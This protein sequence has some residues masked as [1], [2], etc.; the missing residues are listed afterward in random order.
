MEMTSSYNE[1]LYKKR[2]EMK[3]SKKKF[4][5]FLGLPKIYYSYCE[6]G[7]FKP[8][9]KYVE[10]ISSALGIDFSLYLEGA[11]S[12]PTP[13]PDKLGWFER[14]YKKI[15]AKL[16]VRIAF[17]VLLIGSLFMTIFGF[18]RYNYTMDH[19]DEFFN[20]RYLSFAYAMREKGGSTFSLLHEMTRPEI[21]TLEDGKFYSISTS[22]QNYALRSLSAYANYQYDT[23]SLYYIVPNDAKDSLLHV[24]VQ[25]I[26]TDTL[27]KSYGDFYRE[28]KDSS[29][30]LTEGP[31]D[32]T[33]ETIVD[34]KEANS[35]TTIFNSHINDLN[36][37]FTS[38]IKTQLGLDYDFYNEL[39]VDHAQAATD[40]L[41]AEIGSLAIG[42]GGLVLTGGFLFF[43]LFAL[44]FA[45]PKIKRPR[46]KKT[47]PA[48]EN[49]PTNDKIGDD[50]PISR[51]YKS[52]KTDIRFFP[53]I[54]E[55]VFEIVGIFLVLLGSIRIL[56]YTLMLFTTMSYDPAEFNSMNLSLFMY[57]TVGMFLLY[58]IDF[59]VYL[60]DKRSLR[61]S[62]IYLIVFFGLY[63]IEGTMV[64]YLDKT[65]GIITIVDLLYIVPNNFGTIA[66]YYLI[67]VF[68][69]YTPK[70]KKNGKVKMTIFRSAAF[71]P[72]AWIFASSLIFQNYKTWGI[73]FNSWQVYFFNSERPQFSILCCTYLVGLYFLRLF[74][75]KKY[76]P[77]QAERYFNGNKF[78][79]FKN[80]LVC[81][82]IVA[83]SITEFIFKNS[84]KG[85][86]TLG[87]YWEIIYLIPGLLFYHP[88]FGA[89]NKP[90]DYFTLILY[91]IFFG[92]GY[93]LAA[94]IVIG[95]IFIT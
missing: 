12:Y 72:V 57:F 33:G 87:G 21:H 83:L 48:L 26:N 51:S 64:D 44:F 55:T 29:F 41:F 2:M 14:L 40:N 43:F 73:E 34:E 31:Y 71:F 28:D 61:N 4:A 9:K 56:Y 1:F 82:I 85:I 20:D 62:F 37:E 27:T 7:Y 54:P 23:G 70:W 76:G 25:Y 88:H 45:E 39:L 66:C 79:F 52:L 11:S 19:A 30:K 80:L 5:K 17:I 77:E 69:F 81:L 78:Y 90:L 89:R 95:F 22:T 18:A 3:L 36:K 42:I 86:K 8:S 63:I 6:N 65:R 74:F 13:L 50:A 24:K 35:L 60:N 94:I 68:L 46:K 10:K 59:D 47:V 93:V 84:N 75:K 15:L 32:D 91:G 38:L 53:F 58:F 49:V 67:M 16:W 92:L